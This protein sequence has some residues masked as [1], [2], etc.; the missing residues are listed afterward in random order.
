MSIYNMNKYADLISI[1]LNLPTPTIVR[2]FFFISRR[3]RRFGCLADSCALFGGSLSLVFWCNLRT[4]CGQRGTNTEN[5]YIQAILEVY[6][7]IFSGRYC[8]LFFVFFF[9]LFFF[10]YYFINAM[11]LLFTLYIS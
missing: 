4:F 7:L 10:F 9:L 1:L 11:I 2:R 8:F 5:Y 6:I 3:L